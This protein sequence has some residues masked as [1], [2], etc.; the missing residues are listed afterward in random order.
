MEAWGAIRWDFG[1][2]EQVGTQAPDPTAI[3]LSCRSLRPTEEAEP[4]QG[5]RGPGRAGP[6]GRTPCLVWVTGW[7]ACSLWAPESPRPWAH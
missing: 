1:A 4:G 5:N 2:T 6:W 7:E 3:P